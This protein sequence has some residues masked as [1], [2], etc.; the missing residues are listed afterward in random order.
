MSR[1]NF[2]SEL[3]KSSQATHDPYTP[4]SRQIAGA[5]QPDNEPRVRRGV[6][7]IDPNGD[8]TY[9]SVEA[10]RDAQVAGLR[11][12]DSDIEGQAAFIEDA[13]E[14]WNSRYV[15]PPR[16]ITSFTGISQEEDHD[17][18]CVIMAARAVQDDVHKERAAAWEKHF[19]LRKKQRE[20]TMGK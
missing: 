6:I 5:V 2:G 16:V 15:L 9:W 12:D 17:R 13:D 7:E 11:I 4:P 8:V 20:E 10:L 18:V 3:L 19:E 1:P 14:I